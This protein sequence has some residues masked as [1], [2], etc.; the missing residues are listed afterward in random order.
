[1]TGTVF[2]RL[3]KSKT[4]FLS[5]MLRPAHLPPS[6]TDFQLFLTIAEGCAG[7]TQS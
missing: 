2:G 4:S 7:Y 3:L 1:M 5:G 6:V